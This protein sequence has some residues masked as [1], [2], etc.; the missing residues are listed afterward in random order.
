MPKSAQLNAST[1]V[2]AF[3]LPKNCTGFEVQNEEAVTVRLRMDSAVSLVGDSDKGIPIL[4]REYYKRDFP[5]LRQPRTVYAM[6][7][8]G[9]G[10][11]TYEPLFD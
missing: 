6:I 5:I 8:S 4:A 9:T 1:S 2:A 3:T 7:A 11:L 10:Y